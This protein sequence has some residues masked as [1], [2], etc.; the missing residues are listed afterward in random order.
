MFPIMVSVVVAIGGLI[1]VVVRLKRSREKREMNRYIIEPEAFHSL[2]DSNP[3]VVVVDVRQPLDLLAYS[4]IIPGA[5]RIPPKDVIANPS[6]IPKD[7][8]TVVYCTCNSE[9][10]SRDILR[11]ALALNFSRLKILRGGLAAWKEK[12]YPVVPYVESFHLDTAG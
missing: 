9:E 12:G 6:L 11:R 10:T 8:D 4:E 1:F 3:N 7:V 5:K 2:L